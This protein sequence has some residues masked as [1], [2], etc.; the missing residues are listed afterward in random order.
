MNYEFR[1]FCPKSMPNGWSP[2]PIL[3]VRQKYTPSL[4]EVQFGNGTLPKWTEWVAIPF[5]AE[6]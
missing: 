4:H 6:Q 1:W 3:Q 2:N 5:V